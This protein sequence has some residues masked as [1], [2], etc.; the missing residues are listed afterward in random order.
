MENSIEALNFQEI[1]GKLRELLTPGR[2]G[3]KEDG[4]LFFNNEFGS[5]GANRGCV[6]VDE[7]AVRER[8]ENKDK[9]PLCPIHQ[10]CVNTL[11]GFSCSDSWDAVCAAGMHDCHALAD[12]RARLLTYLTLGFNSWPKRNHPPP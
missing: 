3:S 1:E 12:C 2:K 6:D 9:G 8:P 4:M 7:C 11:G 5:A 10:R